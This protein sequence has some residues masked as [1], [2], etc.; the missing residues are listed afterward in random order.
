MTAVCN[1]TSHENGRIAMTFPDARIVKP[2]GH[3]RK[4]LKVVSQIK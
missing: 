3:H 4:V 1:M 2:R